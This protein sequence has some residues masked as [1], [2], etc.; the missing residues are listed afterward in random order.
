M[1]SLDPRILRVGIEVNGRLKLYEGMDIKVSGMKYANPIQN[2]CQVQISNLEKNTR[3]FILTETSPFN[4]NR[5]PKRLIVEAGRVST[6]TSR[7]FIGDITTATISQPPD[8][9]L[10][11][12]ALT[13]NFQK[14]NLISRNQRAQA[15]LRRISEQVATDI[16][17]TL[18]FQATDKNIGN[19]SYSGA[20][21][22]QIDK[23]SESGAVD[24]YLD[25]GVLVV[26]DINV[27]LNGK[28]RIL[29]QETGMIGIPEV[30]E[31]G[32]KVRFLFDNQTTIG[33]AL[34][35]TSI[36][37]PSINGLYAIYKLGFELTSRDVPFYL[38]A[39]CKRI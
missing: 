34:D 15:K 29:S 8:I 18:D 30:T 13:G 1:A 38:V 17:A 19:Y 14:G 10:S 25:D 26:K 24:A 21:I 9:I 32:L 27:P 4:E 36:L 6:G 11:M 31:H 20:A 12:K 39:E 22:K 5:T 23:I 35:I 7:V 3:D 16:G 2:E 33:G 28:T 37:N